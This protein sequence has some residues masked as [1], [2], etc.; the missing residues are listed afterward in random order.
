MCKKRRR[1]KGASATDATLCTMC[2]DEK[3]PHSA[4]QRIAARFKGRIG[5]GRGRG[6][7]I[8]RLRG[9]KD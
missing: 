9:G 4:C 5:R 8:G 2:V 3:A 6:I 1:R 7:G